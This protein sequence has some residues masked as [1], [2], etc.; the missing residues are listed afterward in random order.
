MKR[1]IRVSAHGD[2]GPHWVPL[3][4]AG[5]VAAQEELHPAGQG[6]AGGLD[7]ESVPAPGGVGAGDVVAELVAAQTD[8]VHVPCKVGSA[9]IVQVALAFLDDV[10]LTLAAAVGKFGCVQGPAEGEQ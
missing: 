8:L 6:A 2:Q 9:P 10:L 7:L 4:H 5:L 3:P 1:P